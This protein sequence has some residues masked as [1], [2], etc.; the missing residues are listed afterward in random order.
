MAD[1]SDKILAGIQL[2]LEEMRDM[3]RE[4]QEDRRRADQDRRR[5]DERFDAIVREGREQLA[6][7]AR[8]SVRR[9]RTLNRSLLAIAREGRAIRRVLDEHTVL[10]RTIVRRLAIRANGRHGNGPSRR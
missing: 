4:A 6:E 7:Y 2:V 5:A 8:D 1:K 3:R 10:L 9:E